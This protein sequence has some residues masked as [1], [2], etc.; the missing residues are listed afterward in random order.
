MSNIKI[1]LLVPIFYLLT[2]VPW[3][4]KFLVWIVLFC[5]KLAEPLQKIQTELALAQLQKRPAFGLGNDREENN[6]IMMMLVFGWVL[7][8][9]F[10]ILT[11]YFYPNIATLCAIFKFILKDPKGSVAP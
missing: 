8:P 11:F 10:E 1:L 4:C 3:F 2:Y 6:K 9:L 7:F 5:G